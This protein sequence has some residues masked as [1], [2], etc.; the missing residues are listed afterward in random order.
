MFVLCRVWL[1]VETLIHTSGTSM[2]GGVTVK[3]YLTQR[4][5]KQHLSLGQFKN[6]NSLSM[7]K[8]KGK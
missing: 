5:R 4:K 7:S 2:C 8:V 6:Y 1:N 3:S